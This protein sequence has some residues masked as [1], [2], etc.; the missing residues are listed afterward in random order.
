MGLGGAKGKKE[1][2]GAGVGAAVSR[3][4][5]RKFELDEE[6]MLRNAKEERE[7]ARRAIDGE[8]VG[9]SLSLRR[10]KGYILIFSTGCQR[11]APLLL[12]ALPHTFDE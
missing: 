3:G 9:S 2:D 10:P 7:R 6:E 4:V 8:K 12:G 1:G 5:K 11:E